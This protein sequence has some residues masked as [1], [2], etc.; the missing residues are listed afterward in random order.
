MASSGKKRGIALACALILG[1]VI[2]LIPPFGELTVESMRFAGIFVA[3]IILLVTQ[4]MPDW[5]TVLG[6]SALLVL[7]KTSTIGVVF[8][9][10]S[11]STIWLVIMVFALAAAIG[12]SGLLKRIALKILTWFKPT[13]NGAV[14]AMMCAGVISG[15]LIP[16]ANAKVNI[17]IPVA[18][19]VTSQ[20]GFKERSKPALG[21]FSAVYLP[22]MIG[23][24]AFL[25][26]SVYVSIML[27][28]IT[29]MTF[30]MASWFVATCL[31]FVVILVGTWLWC[32]IYCKPDEKVE[33]PA[34]FYKKRYESLGAMTRN[35]KVAAVVLVA[36]LLLWCTSSL[37][38]MDTGMVGW[39]AVVIFVIFGLFTGADL[40]G[41]IPWTTVVF[42]GGLLGMGN[43]ISS[44]G[45]SDVIAN[46][47]G[48]VVAPVVSSPWIFIPFLCIFT[49]LLRFVVVE[50]LT[51]LLI[52]L[53]IFSPLLASAGI[54]MFVLVFVQFMSAMV[55]N[56]SYQNPYPHATI[57]AA[58]GKY[59]TFNELKKD[60]YLFMVLNL[61][62]CTL[63]V[64]L[65]YALGL[66]F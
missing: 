23:C 37:H 57:A 62:G 4:A 18:T 58:G 32:V 20:V 55:W 12:G 3:V 8:S 34:D 47:L 64:P 27:G 15:P 1:V 7:T 56:V 17:L 46:L 38:G 48:P 33:L 54:S 63:S 61:I 25:S 5:A 11:G 16:S 35:E 2:A 50:Q 49:Y 51:S 13:Y 59:V 39:M 36:A 66:L 41:K 10:Y 22:S 31:W 40:I 19:E 43:L 29:D 53:A 21:L 52:T 6:A 45:W 60:S 28:F 14:L 24:N 30:N 42:I 65:W 9:A 26:G 44:L